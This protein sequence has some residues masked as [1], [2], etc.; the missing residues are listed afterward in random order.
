NCLRIDNLND[1]KLLC[2]DLEQYNSEAD[3]LLTKEELE[4]IKKEDM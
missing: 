2:Y 4:K 1:C 3:G